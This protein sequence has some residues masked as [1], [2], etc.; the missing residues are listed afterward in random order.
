MENRKKDVQVLVVD[1]EEGLRN[2]LRAS[3]VKA[4]YKVLLRDKSIQQ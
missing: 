3:L 2:L 4:G 1:D